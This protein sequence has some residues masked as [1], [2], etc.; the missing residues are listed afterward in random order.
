MNTWTEN[1]YKQQAMNEKLQTIIDSSQFSV[2]GGNNLVHVI[3][4]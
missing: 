4:A 2:I 3:V 1:R